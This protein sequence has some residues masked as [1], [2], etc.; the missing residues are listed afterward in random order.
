MYGHRDVAQ[1]AC[2]GDGGYAWLPQIRAEIAERLDGGGG[3]EIILDNPSATFTQDWA[4][5]VGGSQTYGN[6]YRWRSTGITTGLA[7]WRPAIPQ[8]GYYAVQFWW[9]SG[10]NRNPS[11]IVGVRLNSRTST[12]R[13]NQQTGGGLWNE[14]GVAYMPKGTNSLVGLSSAGPGGFV[15]VADA[16]RFV[17]V[18]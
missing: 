15:V 5:A 10:A 8:A 4:V 3:T 11:T 18:N 1:T 17:R 12:V 16:V 14:I 6:D 13:V 9:T 7:I 2:P